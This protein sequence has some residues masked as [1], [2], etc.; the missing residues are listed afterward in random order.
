MLAEVSTFHARVVVIGDSSVGKTSI[1][2]Q[3][4]E[5]TFN[6]FEPSTVGSNYQLYVEEIQ[7]TKVEIQIWDTAGQEKFRSLGPIYFRNAVAAIAVYDQ[8]NRLTFEHLDKWIHDFTEVAGATTTI[9]I[10]GNKSD[11]QSEEVPFVEAEKWANDRKYLIAQTSAL[12]GAGVKELFKKL[13]VSILQ[14][15]SANQKT[16][17]PPRPV[18]EKK[19]CDC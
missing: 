2:N 9:A 14:N 12:T 8:T 17:R 13:A 7:G 1:L 15:Q 18:Q 10:A 4:V 16:L 6:P 3:L 5:H 19:K 11:L